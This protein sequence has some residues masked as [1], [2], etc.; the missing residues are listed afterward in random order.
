MV[1]VTTLLFYNFST[2]SGHSEVFRNI[3]KWEAPLKGVRFNME[4]FIEKPDLLEIGNR[5]WL[6]LVMSL[7]NLDNEKSN[8]VDLV[9][10]GEPHPAFL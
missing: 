9:F 3:G 6:H 1:L 4:I 7:D 2:A 8:K 10:L 5:S